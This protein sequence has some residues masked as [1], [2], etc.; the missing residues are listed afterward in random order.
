MRWP[1][2]PTSIFVNPDEICPDDVRTTARGSRSVMRTRKPSGSTRETTALG[3]MATVFNSALIAVE[4][5]APDAC[6]RDS[7]RTTSS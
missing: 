4:V 6:L 7:L 3:P 2:S 5:C 1:S